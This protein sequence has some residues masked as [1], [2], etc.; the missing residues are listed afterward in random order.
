M[1]EEKC[2]KDE[3]LQPGRKEYEFKNAQKETLLNVLSLMCGYVVWGM[4]GAAAWNIWSVPGWRAHKQSTFKKY[5]HSN[6]ENYVEMS[7]N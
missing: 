5:K 4:M 1:T 6:P 3:C 7:K 2:F